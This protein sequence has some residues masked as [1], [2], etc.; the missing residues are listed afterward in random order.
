MA[1][2]RFRRNLILVTA[3]HVLAL[4]AFFYFSKREIK[5]PSGEVVWMNP[6]AFS[7][8][9]AEASEPLKME[10]DDPEPTPE[11]TPESTPEPTPEPTPQPT[12][13]ST[14]EPTPEPTPVATPSESDIPLSTPT[15][16]PTPT[17]KP[18]PTPSPTP[19]ATPKP[20]PKPTQK[21]SP[22]PSPQP[23]PKE[24]PK[25]SPKPSA[26]P[27]ASPKAPA[28]ASAKSSP[29]ASPKSSPG[30]SPGGSP[31]TAASKSGDK[32]ASQ[33]SGTAAQG[34]GTSSKAGA[35]GEASQFAW[36]HE[37]IHDR[38]YSQWDQ[39]T[40]IFDQSKSFICTVKIR[41][42]K[43]GKIS[44]A[45]I[46][47]SSGNPLM[48]ESVLAAAKRVAQI[49]PPPAGLGSG[50]AYTVNINFELE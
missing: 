25:P 1:D 18:K 3:L 39:P 22:K 33:G 15:P 50:G 28:S 12:P 34:N 42:E 7:T 26:K 30:A 24:S 10:P 49:D 27:S 44:S 23:S 35:G 47:K 11:P 20:T 29:S 8:S 43:D 40:S 6:G 9:V 21:P 46:V 16:T 13:E 38:F 5:K 14:P 48:D 32:P 17:P 2:P 19:K 45:E 41:I 4:V 37:L 31:G 36:Y